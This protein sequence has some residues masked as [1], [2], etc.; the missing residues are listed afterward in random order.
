MPRSAT[1]R[2][3]AAATGAPF[4][5]VTRPETPAARWSAM[6]TVPG[7]E[8]AATTPGIVAGR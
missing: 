7:V 8:T 1:N 2:T 5:S 6:A 3:R 4:S